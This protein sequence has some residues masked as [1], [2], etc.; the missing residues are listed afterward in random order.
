M[1]T[2][3]LVE[4]ARNVVLASER[5]PR[6]HQLVR[7]DFCGADDIGRVGRDA[8]ESGNSEFLSER[9]DAIDVEAGV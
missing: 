3:C 8:L 1:S 4:V 9:G 6:L 5:W 2:K 7:E